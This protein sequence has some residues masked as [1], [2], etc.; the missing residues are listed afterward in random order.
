[1][2]ILMVLTSHDQ[3]VGQALKPVSGLKRER[4]PTSF[5][6]GRWRAV[7]SRLTQGRAASDRSKERSAGKSDARPGF[8]TA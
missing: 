1:M 4:L 7:D 8:S 2:K 3:L 6:E 5:S